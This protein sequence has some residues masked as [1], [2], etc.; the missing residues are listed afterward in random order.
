MN[1]RSLPKKFQLKNYD[2]GVKA[3][4]KTQKKKKKATNIAA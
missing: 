3:K 4:K 2:K 1:F